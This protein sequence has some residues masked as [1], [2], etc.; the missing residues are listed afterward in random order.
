MPGSSLIIFLMTSEVS[1]LTILKMDWPLISDSNTVGAIPYVNA[2][3]MKDDSNAHERK[4]VSK[5]A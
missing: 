5:K 2:K 3:L 1:G 4:G